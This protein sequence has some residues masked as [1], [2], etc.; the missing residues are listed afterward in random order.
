[1]REVGGSALHLSLP[2]VNV[3]KYWLRRRSGG[4]ADATNALADS[5]MNPE[6]PVFCQN[7]VSQFERRSASDRH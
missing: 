2:A 7:R 1:M 4:V 5:S 3:L 6:N